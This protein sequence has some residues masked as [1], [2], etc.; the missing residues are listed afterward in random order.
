[1]PSIVLRSFYI[2]RITKIKTTD[3]PLLGEEVKYPELSYI[4]FMRLQS[5]AATLKSSWV[6]PCRIKHTPSY[7]RK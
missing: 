5:S 2:A 7:D 6:V 1:M 3:N 4:A